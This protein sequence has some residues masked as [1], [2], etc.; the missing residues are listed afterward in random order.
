[1]RPNA[2]LPHVPPTNMLLKCLF[3]LNCISLC[4]CVS[5]GCAGRTR[6]WTGD[7][8]VSSQPTSAPFT[9]M[10]D[11]IM[12]TIPL[13]V[14]FS[15][16]VLEPARPG[17]DSEAERQLFKLVKRFQFRS[18]TLHVEIRR[19]WFVVRYPSGT[20]PPVERVDKPTTY[21]SIK[22]FVWDEAGK[23]VSEA[24]LQRHPYA[25]VILRREDETI[26]RPEIDFVTLLFIK[27][28]TNGRTRATVRTALFSYTYTRGHW[29]LSKALLFPK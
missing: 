20:F 6:E 18:G 29:R 28:V 9:S 15:E 4:L 12:R 25:E 22:P 3:A 27:S 23:R 11:D 14:K 21:G 1:M 13:E 10:H 26:K 19:H 8:H 16:E 2:L 7:E 5:V 17:V 24:K